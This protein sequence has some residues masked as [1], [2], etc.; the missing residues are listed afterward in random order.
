MNARLR[1]K[2]IL[3]IAKEILGLTGLA[4]L[5]LACAAPTWAGTN[6]AAGNQAATAPK[7]TTNVSPGAPVPAAAPSA[8]TERPTGGN[9]EGITVHGHWAIDVK[10]PDGSLA[11]HVEFENSLDP[12]FTVISGTVSVPV[13]G[14]AAYLAGALA[15]QALPP[16]GNW[17]VVLEGPQGLNNLTL[18]NSNELI[19]PCEA[20]NLPLG[21]NIGAAIP[22]NFIAGVA[23]CLIGQSAPGNDLGCTGAAATP[24]VG[25]SC[26]LTA[27]PST[28]QV[29]AGG[30]TTTVPAVQLSGNV[31]VTNTNSPQI[32]TVATLLGN[33]CGLAQPNQV[34]TCFISPFEA[35]VTAT[36]TSL[37]STNVPGGPIQVTAN[38][39]VAVIV[40]ISFQ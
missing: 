4:C 26:N 3:R 7:P 28:V 18:L 27:L 36:L 33:P 34:A 37:T 39:T 21:R 15:G 24:S 20:L 32:S 40:T 11:K 31:V 30:V 2:N 38:Q 16:A 5:A 19:A 14:G 22:Y 6:Q 12:G 29:A 10:N 25:V 13:P 8:S 9:H 17:I 23:A 35:G 1:D